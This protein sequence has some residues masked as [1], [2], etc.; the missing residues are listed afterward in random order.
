MKKSKVTAHKSGGRW[1]M[2][3]VLGIALTWISLPASN[4]EDKIVFE[5]VAPQ[6]GRITIEGTSTLHDWE[7]KGDTIVGRM[8]LD[9]A[10]TDIE[11]ALFDGNAIPEVQVEIPVE[12]LESGRRRMDTETAKALNA[13]RYKFITYKLTSMERAPDQPAERLEAGEENDVLHAVA[14]GELTI[15]GQTRTVTFPVTIADRNGGLTIRGAA[16]L[17][18]TDFGVEPPR[19]M[20]GALRVGDDINVQFVWEP[21]Q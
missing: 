8:S 11:S 13:A 9:A 14:T 10:A 18:M 7:I 17:K 3:F 21:N 6:A 1:T 15:S 2:V 19:L 4:G 16:D 12:S 20:L 5:S